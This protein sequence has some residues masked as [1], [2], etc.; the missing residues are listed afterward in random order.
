MNK[1]K[2]KIVS[3]LS[4]LFVLD[5]ATALE[6][7]NKSGRLACDVFKGRDYVLNAGAASDDDGERMVIF[8]MD[9]K[10]E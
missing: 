9:D 6:L 1:S 4:V 3:F 5:M 10:N 2:A 7:Y 8:T